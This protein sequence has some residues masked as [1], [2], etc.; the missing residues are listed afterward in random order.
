MSKESTPETEQAPKDK[1]E[2]PSTHETDPPPASKDKQ[3]KPGASAVEVLMTS[4]TAVELPSGAT[5]SGEA[6]TTF[7]M[8]PKDA[9]FIVANGYGI[10]SD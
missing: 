2:A 3:D 7:S 5:Y 1:W 8:L 10:A 6:G 4:N 9:E